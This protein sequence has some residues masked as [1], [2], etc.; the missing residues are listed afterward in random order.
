MLIGKPQ[1]V[2]AFPV[3]LIHAGHSQVRE[4]LKLGEGAQDPAASPP[5]P[6]PHCWVRDL[7]TSSGRPCGV[8]PVASSEPKDAFTL[9]VQNSLYPA[10]SWLCNWW[11]MLLLPQRDCLHPWRGEGISKSPF[12]SS[13]IVSPARPLIHPLVFSEPIVQI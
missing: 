11:L 12:P 6:G 1:A 4:V 3:G 8:S 5:A 13:R 10:T 2:P 9:S 7:V